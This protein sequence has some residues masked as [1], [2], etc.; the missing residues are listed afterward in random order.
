ML[1]VAGAPQH[2]ATS[3][4][5]GTWAGPVR[6]CDGIEAHGVKVSLAHLRL[7]I[8]SGL[9]AIGHGWMAPGS[10]CILLVSSNVAQIHLCAT[11]QVKVTSV[12]L[13]PPMSVTPGSRWGILSSRK[14]SLV[15]ESMIL[16]N[17][18][19]DLAHGNWHLPGTQYSIAESRQSSNYD[20]FSSE[21]NPNRSPS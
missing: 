17:V 3:R 11:L 7:Q 20:S 10:I 8:Y 18:D 19:L 16:H 21:Q 12:A 1:Q 5:L 9:P 4:R 13:F 6:N 14:L 2:R 15:P